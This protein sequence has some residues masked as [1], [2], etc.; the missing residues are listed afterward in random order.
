MILFC[1]CF[2]T[3]RWIFRLIQLRLNKLVSLLVWCCSGY[4]IVY[5]VSWLVCL[6]GWL[7][8]W[9]DG[10]LYWARDEFELFWIYNVLQVHIVWSVALTLFWCAH[11]PFYIRTNVVCLL[12]L[13]S[14]SMLMYI[15]YGFSSFFSFFG[16][17]FGFPLQFELDYCNACVKPMYFD[18]YAE[19]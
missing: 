16:M 14:L 6:V 5:V 11:D 17:F 1:F 18:H 10:V 8:A 12:S 4:M 15:V 9:N 19:H 2:P 7:S 3:F 13:S